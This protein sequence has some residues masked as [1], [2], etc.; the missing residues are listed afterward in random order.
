[1]LDSGSDVTSGSLPVTTSIIVNLSRSSSDIA[2]YI[3]DAQTS[4][5]LFLFLF[6]TSFKVEVISK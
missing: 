3:E 1:M 6:A 5:F 2:N 4:L